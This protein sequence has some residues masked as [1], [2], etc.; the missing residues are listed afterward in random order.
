MAGSCEHGN[1]PSDSKSVWEF[2]DQLNYSQLLKKD[3]LCGVSYM[4]VCVRPFNTKSIFYI[5]IF[6]KENATIHAIPHIQDGGETVGSF[7]ST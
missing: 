6:S 4:F 3:W 1:S 2:L 7:L 5:W